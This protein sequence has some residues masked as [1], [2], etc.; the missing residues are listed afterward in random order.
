[1]TASVDM[2]TRR[3]LDGIA[4]APRKKSHIESGSPSQASWHSSEPYSRSATESTEN[5]PTVLLHSKASPI[6]NN[7]NTLEPLGIAADAND[8]NEKHHPITSNETECSSKPCSSRSFVPCNDLGTD[9]TDVRLKVAQ[10]FRLC[11]KEAVLFNY[12]TQAT[13]WYENCSSEQSAAGLRWLLDRGVP[14]NQRL[15]MDP[16]AGSPRVHTL[17]P[18]QFVAKDPDLA[19]F[20]PVL[21]QAGAD[22]EATTVSGSTPVLLAL[23]HNNRTRYPSSPLKQVLRYRQLILTR[24]I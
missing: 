7:I 22:I 18:L 19:H 5:Y 24:R 3:P 12:F 1:M 13:T 14:V 20:I 16:S 10:L 4:D 21:V 2:P 11:D 17:T 9:V 8:D 23:K 6:Q 15:T